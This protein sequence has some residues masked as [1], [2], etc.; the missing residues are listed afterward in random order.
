MS[1]LTY[2]D[3]T[4]EQRDDDGMV[5]L[6]Q[7]AKAN[8]VDV[9]HWR[10]LKSTEAYISSLERTTGI[11]ANDVFVSKAGNPENGGGTWAHYLLALD[12][13]RWISA[14]FAIW[15][16]QHIHRLI[17]TGKTELEANRQSLEAAIAPKPKLSEIRQAARMFRDAFGDSYYQR[18]LQQMVSRHYPPLAGSAPA[19]QETASL[20]GEALLTPTQIAA[21]LGWWSKSN[22][23]AADP[24]RVNKLLAELGYQ[25]QIGGRWSA[26]E[27]AL[28]ANL[29]DRKPVDTNSRTQRDQLLWSADILAVLREHSQAA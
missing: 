22:P 21:D 28:S 2:K 6:T 1:T 11:P 17:T 27:K 3:Q 5:S 25:E 9:N 13:G 26:T 15:C 8:G 20:P 4:I 7:M 12:F 10:V 16:D 23:S 14:D 29:C 18:Y 24:R 19:P